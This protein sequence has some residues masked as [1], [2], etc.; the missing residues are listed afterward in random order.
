M[1]PL[2]AQPAGPFRWEGGVVGMRVEG[3]KVMR[4]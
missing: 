2:K 1:G 4:G 3:P